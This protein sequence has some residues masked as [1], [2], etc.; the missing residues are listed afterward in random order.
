M[1]ST[2]E[3]K[4]REL[5]NEVS[6]PNYSTSTS[7][8]FSNLLHDTISAINHSLHSIPLNLLVTADVAPSFV[9]DIG[10]D[11]V[12]F[13]FERP[14]SIEI[15]GSYT[16]H[17]I[18]KPDIN[19]DLLVRLPKE[20]FHEKDYLNHRYHA[21][22]CLYLCIIKK[23]LSSSP[24][25]HK[26]EWSTLQNEA[27]KPVLLVYPATKLV[28]APGFFVRL[29]PTAT[30]LFSIQKLNLERNNVRALNHGGISHPTPKYNSSILEDTF[31]EDTMDSIK[32]V[33]LGW[34]ELGEALILL[35][36]WARQ[37]T[38]IYAHDC[39]NGFLLS[40]ILSNLAYENKVNN[41]MKAMQ[42]FRVTLNSIAN[43]GFWTRGLCLKTKDK[44][45]ALKEMQSKQ[46]AAFNLAFRM[47]RVGCIQL[48]EEAASTLQC[49]EK[50]R[51][52][53]FEEIFM[54]RVDF[55]TKHD[56]CIRYKR[57]NIYKRAE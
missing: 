28:E 18:A 43:P 3:L 2:E 41:S 44:N 46:H 23:Y 55:P 8:T 34:K 13:K 53:G 6:I 25:I 20:C 19:V 42:I 9:K 56:H 31:M 7:T 35:K 39:L 21:K 50:C 54:T 52:G 30:S 37:R 10:A 47:T 57:T 17:C 14:V 22:R 45:A 29:I 51:D 48:Q 33:F 32:K 1:E 36:V 40:V 15:G 16:I 5:L 24:L 26:V 49:I 11:K 38:S 12:D 27:R 4:T